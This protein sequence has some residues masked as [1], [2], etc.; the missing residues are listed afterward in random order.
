M[1]T[2][3]DHCRV[4]NAELRDYRQDDMQIRRRLVPCLSE[5]TERREV[6]GLRG[7]SLAGSIDPGRTGRAGFASRLKALSGTIRLSM[8]LS[9]MG[10]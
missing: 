2:R 1:P 4:C 9:G 10:T 3:D 8:A 5:M 6:S 7:A